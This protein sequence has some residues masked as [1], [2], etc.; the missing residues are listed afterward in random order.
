[1]PKQ[2]FNR[3]RFPYRN[4]FVLSKLIQISS[5]STGSAVVGRIA[6]GFTYAKLVQEFQLT[7]EPKLSLEA[8]LDFYNSIKLC[9][10]LQR[11][12]QL[13]T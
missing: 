2:K 5:H 8:D 4:S 1:M 11:P 3:S 12:E 7:H 6:V 13:L 9:M 10:K